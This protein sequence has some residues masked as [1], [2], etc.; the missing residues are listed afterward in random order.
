ME[1]QK[2]IML[3][4]DA[5]A[6]QQLEAFINEMPFKYAQPLLQLITP[7]VK[8]VMDQEKEKVKK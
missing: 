1:Q 4:M 7:H 8:E 2:P 6:I 5:K 3:V